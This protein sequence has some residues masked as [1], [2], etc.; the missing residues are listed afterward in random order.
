MTNKDFIAKLAQRTG[1]SSEDTQKMV[2]AVVEKMG[3]HFQEVT[4]VL[5]PTPNL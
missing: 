5:I 2:N 4:R 3:D 1:Y